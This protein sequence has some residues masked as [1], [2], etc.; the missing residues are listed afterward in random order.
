MLHPHC[1]PALLLSAMLKRA[2][3][4][5]TLAA[6][7]QRLIFGLV[8]TR[9]QRMEEQVHGEALWKHN[10]FVPGGIS[11]AN[12]NRPWEA[13]AQQEAADGSPSPAA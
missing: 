1:V 8:L 7:R 9:L 11:R 13:E 3:S 5:V 6:T 12:K 4:C 10:S 2:A